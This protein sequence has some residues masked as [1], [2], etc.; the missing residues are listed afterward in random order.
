[1]TIPRSVFAALV[2]A[3][4]LSAALPAFAQ[5]TNL[6]GSP[7]PTPEEYAANRV[8]LKYLST[9][10]GSGDDRPE[11][12]KSAFNAPSLTFDPLATHTVHFT[13]SRNT[14]AGPTMWSASVPPSASLWTMTTLSSGVVRWR[15]I[16][17]NATFG[18][19]KK[20]QIVGYPGGLHVWTYVRAVNQ[21]IAS[22]PLVPGVDQA[23]VLVEIES[24]GVGV[25][26]DG[27]TDNCV[28]TG[29]TQ[30]CSVM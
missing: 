21:N 11:I 20:A 9:G 22:A 26:Y 16:D 1:M 19:V 10:P 3:S 17:P 14:I 30:T 28:G 2:S 13:V 6:T 25:C 23:H 4:L 15:Y 8:R 5:C 12:Q 7:A 29:N 24:G 27:A 18:G